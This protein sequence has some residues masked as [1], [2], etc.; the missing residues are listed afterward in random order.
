MV[1]IFLVPELK[2]HL[3]WLPIMNSVKYVLGDG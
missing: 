1:V 2:H 3:S